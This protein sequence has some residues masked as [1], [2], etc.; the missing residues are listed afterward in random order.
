MG[1]REEIIAH[2]RRSRWTW[3]FWW[4]VIATLGIYLYL[5][6]R[7]KITLTNRRLIER[8]GGVLGGEEI[9]MNL[10][11]I[12]DIRVKTSPMGAIFGYGLF[13]ADS[14]GSDQAEISFNGLGRPHKLKE[15]IIDLQ[16]DGKLD[17]GLK[18]KAGQEE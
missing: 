6:N 15:A 1:Q 7:N 10:D 13:E 9:S 18:T 17:G 14:A 2:Y 16:H 8:R 5:W 3:G 11:R 12:T 4:R